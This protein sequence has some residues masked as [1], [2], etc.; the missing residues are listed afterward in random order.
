MDHDELEALRELRDFQL[1]KKSDSSSWGD[2]E[3]ICECKCLSVEDIRSEII[4]KFDKEALT[5][6]KIETV[7]LSYLKERL[8]LG[9]GCSSCLKSFD[10]WKDKI[11]QERK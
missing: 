11:F 1:R 3:L 7:H 5:T 9:S 8:G 10:D 4:D 6:G 2:Q